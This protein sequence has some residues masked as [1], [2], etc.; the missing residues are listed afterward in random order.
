[1]KMRLRIFSK[2]GE[3]K[4]RMILNHKIDMRKSKEII[5]EETYTIKL[6]H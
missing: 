2:F 6:N 1:M 3:F 5:G 4:R